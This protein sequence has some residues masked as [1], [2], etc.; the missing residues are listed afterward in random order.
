MPRPAAVPPQ[1]PTV[2]PSAAWPSTDARA[3]ETTLTPPVT[4]SPAP[5]A[6][7]ATPAWSAAPVATPEP[8]AAGGGWSPTPVPASTW[9]AP[10]SS[11]EDARPFASVPGTE[12]D[13]E[14]DE[15]DERP[16]HPYT[17]LHLIVLAVVAFVLGFL[18]VLL[19]SKA[20]DDAAAAA[21][22]SVTTTTTRAGPSA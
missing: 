10:A 14:Y 19:L 9:G 11:D 13:D 8:A 17:W 2:A 22:P 21:A 6:A 20:G 18:I 16:R 12:D 1:P 15:V 5:Q 3:A 7:A 4:S